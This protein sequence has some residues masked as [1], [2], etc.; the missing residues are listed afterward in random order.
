MLAVC[1]AGALRRSELV[2]LRLEDIAFSE[3]GATIHIRK[4][5]TDFQ[6]IGA[7][8]ALPNGRSLQ[9]VSALKD[10]L[11]AANIIRGP[12]FRPVYK[13]RVMP[14]TVD[15][16]LVSRVLKAYL[17][18]ANRDPALYGAHSLRAGFITSAA[19]AGVSLERIMDHT[20]HVESR[21]V[22]RYVRR[23]NLFRDH[24]GEAFL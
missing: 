15:P 10:W 24:P 12:V 1:F 7:H 23:A 9:A 21:N 3:Q 6:G 2:A 16:Y 4:S 18:R 17:K 13:N 22:R 11:H 20:R 14:R 5:K 19:E 8:I